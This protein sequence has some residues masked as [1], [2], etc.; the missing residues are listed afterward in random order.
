[1]NST[2]KSNPEIHGASSC[3]HSSATSS[4]SSTVPD[5]SEL[6]LQRQKAEQTAGMNA[7]AVANFESLLK[8]FPIGLKLTHATIAG[9]PFRKRVGS[10]GQ[11]WNLPCRCQCGTQFEVSVPHIRERQPSCG[12]QKIKRIKNLNLSHGFSSHPILKHLL[13]TYQGIAKRAG[14]SKGYEHALLSD[15]W[16]RPGENFLLWALA[17]G[18]EPGMSVDRIDNAQGYCPENCRIVTDIENANNRSSSVIVEYGGEK[19]SL[20]NLCRMLNKDYRKVQQRIRSYD[21]TLERALEGADLPPDI[22][23][24][25]FAAVSEDGTKFII[26][27]TACFRETRTALLRKGFLQP[28]V[29][30]P[31]DQ[32]C[33]GFVRQ[34]AINALDDLGFARFG[35]GEKESK[36]RGWIAFSDAERFQRE[37]DFDAFMQELEDRVPAERLKLADKV[38][39]LRSKMTASVN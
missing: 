29:Y 30:R 25:V 33:H 18:W 21:F 8:E 6:A 31:A 37:I 13:S 34:L 11:H 12:C 38:R 39:E 36:S 19:I 2:I 26:G 15:E 3:D 32:T 10:R 35:R 28:L 24:C 9:L 7:R 4:S 16:Q 1:M 27:R 22:G 20:A 17:N 5:S 14:T 23:P